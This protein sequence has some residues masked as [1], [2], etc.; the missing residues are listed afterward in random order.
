MAFAVGKD[1]IAGLAIAV[2]LVG[3][4]YVPAI[5]AISE[6]WGMTSASFI[7]AGI[8]VFISSMFRVC[9]FCTLFGAGTCS[10][11]KR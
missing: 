2:A 7:S 10:I 5:T 11:K 9:V 8:V 6:D 4:G 3:A 1:R